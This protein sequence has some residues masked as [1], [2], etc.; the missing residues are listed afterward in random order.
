MLG[1]SSTVHAAEQE[2]AGDQ[3]D[4]NSMVVRRL[5]WQST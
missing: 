1:Y 3:S 4:E 2:A 5:S